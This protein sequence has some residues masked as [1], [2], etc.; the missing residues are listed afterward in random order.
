LKKSDARQEGGE[1][2]KL[3]LI[4]AM[5]RAA[6]EAFCQ[7]WKAADTEAIFGKKYRKES[8]GF[9]LSNGAGK[10][11]WSGKERNI[12][13]EGELLRLSVFWKRTS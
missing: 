12:A 13:R 5:C 6:C 1:F 7:Q 8:G 2:G 9:Q 3:L 4:V 10:G 11:S